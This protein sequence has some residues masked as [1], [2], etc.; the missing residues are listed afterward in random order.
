LDDQ[1]EELFKDASEEL[2]KKFEFELASG[3]AG[4]VDEADDDFVVAEY[5]SD[6]ESAEEKKKT[7]GEEDNSE[8]HVTKVKVNIV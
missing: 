1:F 2:K 7:T 4:E 3:D 6:D 5:V 8:E